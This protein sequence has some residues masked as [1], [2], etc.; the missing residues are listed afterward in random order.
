MDCRIYDVLIKRM[1]LKFKEWSN[2]YGLIYKTEML[3][4]TFLIISNKKFVG[5]AS[6]AASQDIF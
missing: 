5:G 3:R 2:I 4:A 1:W 6:R